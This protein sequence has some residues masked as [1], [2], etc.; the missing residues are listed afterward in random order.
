MKHAAFVLAAILASAASAAAS[1]MPM[2]IGYSLAHHLVST[3]NELAQAAFDEGLTLLYAYNRVAARSAFERAARADPKMAMA[4][5]G[6]AQSWG[7]NINVPVDPPGERAAYEAVQRARALESGASDVERGYIEALAARYSNA[8][9]P[10]FK[11]LALAYKRAMADL[12]KRYPDDL[13]AATL[14]AESALE[15]HPWQ[16]FTPSG[17]PADGTNDIISTLES[18]ISRDPMHIGANHFYIHA[19]EESQ[20]PERALLSAERL[21][22]FTFAP[23]AAHLVHMPAHTYMRTGFYDLAVERNLHATEHDRTYLAGER[24]FEG[25][26]YYAHNL[27]FLASAYQMEGNYAGAKAAGDLLETE[28]AVIPALFVL[29]RFNRWAEILAYHEPKADPNEPLRLG[30]W[31]FARGLADVGTGDLASAARERHVLA[32]TNRALDVPTIAGSYNGSRVM[33]GLATDVL[34]ARIAMARNQTAAA[35]K[36]FQHAV[37]TQDSLAYI[38]PPDWYYPVRESLGAALLRGGDAK[39]A[40]RVFRDDLSRNLRNGRS[41]FGLAESLK[42]Q[43]DVADAGW[44]QRSFDEAWLHADVT[45][46]INDL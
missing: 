18:V 7:G 4:Q 20:H 29:C 33:F 38:E 37:A 46:S 3:S 19:T 1:P 45:I 43:G 39:A 36:L 27:T 10:D 34:D 42:A 23:G 21:G 2:P 9:R 8:A 44:A 14:Y 17:Q 35:V 28:G 5:W 16:W 11:A 26:A 15:L 24:D 41:L 31:H 40:E 32:D 22:T 6:I 25:S 30:M 12:M 13:D